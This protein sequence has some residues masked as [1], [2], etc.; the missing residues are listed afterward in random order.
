MCF[1]S[2]FCFSVSDADVASA[3]EWSVGFAEVAE[4][5]LRTAVMVVLGVLEHGLKFVGE[6]LAAVGIDAGGEIDLSLARYREMHYTYALGRDIADD[7][8]LGEGDE[9]AVDGELRATEVFGEARQ[10][11]ELRL[12]EDARITAHQ[13]AQQTLLKR[14]LV[15]VVE[16]FLIQGDAYARL[17][18]LFVVVDYI[19]RIRQQ[20]Q[21]RVGGQEG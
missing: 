2:N 5:E 3:T 6:N 20:L 7:M 1:L 21:G 10:M 13:R 4:H 9:R 16:V 8:L 12:G 14:R 11:D 18:I 15:Q 19:S 17:E